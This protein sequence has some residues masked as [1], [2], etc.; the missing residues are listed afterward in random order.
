MSIVLDRMMWIPKERLTKV[1]YADICTELTVEAFKQNEP[2]EPVELFEYDPINDWVGVPREWGLKYTYDPEMR[3][4]TVLPPFKWP[5]FEWPEGYSYWKGQ[6]EAVQACYDWFTTGHYGGRLEASCG[7]G[8]TLMSLVV[9]S[10]LQTPVLVL[11]HKEDLI[12]QWHD[13]IEKFW[14]GAVCGHVQGNKLNYENCHM[15]TAMAQTLYRRGTKIPDEFY[16]AFGLVIFDEGHRYPARTF[17]KVMRLPRARHRLPISATWRRVDGMTCVWEH[18][19]GEVIHVVDTPRLTGDFTQPKWKTKFLDKDFEM[20]DGVTDTVRY[21]TA[22]SRLD[23]YNQRLADQIYNA[24]KSGRKIVFVSDRVKHCQRIQELLAERHFND[25]GLYVGSV[26]HKNEKTGKMGKKKV[27]KEDL[28]AAR[29][30]QVIVATFGMMSEGTDIPDLDTLFFGTPRAEVEQVVGRIQ[31]P[32]KGKKRLLI[33]DAVFQTKWNRTR[34]KAR[35]RTFKKL[36]FTEQ[37]G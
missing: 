16:S 37:E 25:V 36:G 17:E 27:K 31:R 18:H 33:V 34:G 1:E 9:A 7:S 24:T 23:S 2:A 35:K 29:K 5:S 30:C 22:I 6:N 26:D 14:K 13:T 15:V 19:A 21:I 20:F 11:V 8:K 4:D 32:I 28:K 3:D 12:D 10:M